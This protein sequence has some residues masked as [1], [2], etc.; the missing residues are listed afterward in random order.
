LT[1]T[2]FLTVGMNGP[3]SRSFSFAQNQIGVRM[4]IGDDQAFQGKANITK[5]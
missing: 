2:S 4:A 5:C 3:R 1:Q